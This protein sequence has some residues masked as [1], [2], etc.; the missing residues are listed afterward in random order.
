MPR[1][2]RFVEQLPSNA[3]GK[4]DRTLIARLF[5]DLDD[6]RQPRWLGEQWQDAEHCRHSF[7]VPERLAYLRGHFDRFPLVPGVVMVQWALQTAERSFGA[8]GD[9]QRLERLKFQAMLRPG[10]R[11]QLTLVRKPDAVSFTLESAE[12]RHCTATAR[13]VPQVADNV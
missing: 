13:F 2:W 4:L 6:D 7:E 10:M 5:A 1:Y 8:L 12:G 9:F 11:F 3:Q